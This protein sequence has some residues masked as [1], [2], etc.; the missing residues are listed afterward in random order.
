MPSFSYPSTFSSSSNLLQHC[1]FHFFLETELQW[2]FQ[3][4]KYNVTFQGSPAGFLVPGFLFV[5]IWFVFFK[6]L[7]LLFY[8][9]GVAM[10][11]ALQDKASGLLRLWSPLHQWLMPDVS[12]VN[13]AGKHTS[14]L[15]EDLKLFLEEVF[16]CDLCGEVLTPK[17]VTLPLHSSF[18]ALNEKTCFLFLYMLPI[19]TS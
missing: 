17:S 2:Y 6:M 11:L 9:T 1:C 19:K 18:L 13:R 10:W 12:E 3:A 7:F 5:F 4:I 16:L 15:A 14:C 8:S